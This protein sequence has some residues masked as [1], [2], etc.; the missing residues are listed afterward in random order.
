MAVYRIYWHFIEIITSFKSIIGITVYF[1]VNK[2]LLLQA[3]PD[4]RNLILY[5]SRYVTV[6]TCFFTY[7]PYRKRALRITVF[8][9]NA[10][11]FRDTH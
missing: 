6:C 4:Y 10:H 1:I 11:I 5:A 9:F 2:N 3:L 8:G 7:T